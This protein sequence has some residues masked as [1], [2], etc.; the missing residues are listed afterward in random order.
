M[1]HDVGFA[2]A[3][4]GLQYLIRAA[5]DRRPPRSDP[6][7]YRRHDL[8]GQ[9]VSGESRSYRAFRLF[10][11]KLIPNFIAFCAIAPGVRPSSF[12]A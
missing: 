10:E 4:N 5:G 9:R 6:R 12:A 7:Q 2:A 1:S 3:A 8:Q 11:R